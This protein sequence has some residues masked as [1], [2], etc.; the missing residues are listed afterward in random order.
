[1]FDQNIDQNINQNIDQMFHLVIHHYWVERKMS[2]L[3][4]K[5][6]CVCDQTMMRNER[7]RV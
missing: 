6:E 1:M 5:G 7:K 2:Y 3:C 4:F